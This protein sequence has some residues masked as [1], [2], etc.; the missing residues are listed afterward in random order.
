MSAGL[1][2]SGFPLHSPEG[3]RLLSSE[4]CSLWRVFGADWWF[5]QAVNC[6]GCRVKSTGMVFGVSDV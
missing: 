5:F 6:V 2:P 4:D 3:W 1:I